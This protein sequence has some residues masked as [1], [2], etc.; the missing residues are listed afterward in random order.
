MISTW[1]PEGPVSS[2]F[3][4]A[5]ANLLKTMIGSGIL[6]LPYA[7]A[8][9][10]LLLSL[11]GLAVLAYLTQLAIRLVVRCTTHER[12]YGRHGP[13]AILEDGSP[14]DGHGGGSW[15]LISTAA[16]GKVGWSITSA[17]LLTAQL[18]VASSYLDFISQ[19]LVENS[20]LSMA[21]A[22]IILWAV[23]TSMSLLRHLRSVAF[24]SMGALGVYAAIGVLLCY[25][26][27]EA[28]A[29]QEPLLWFDPAG[30][31][32]WF[33]PSLFAF[34]GMGTALSI[35][36]SM[37]LADP[38]PYFAV[39]SS[40]YAIAFLLYGTVATVGYAAWGDD[41]AQVVLDSLPVSTLGTSAKLFLS[42]VLLL[43]YPLQMTAPYHMLEAWLPAGGAWWAVGRAGLVAVTAVA[44]YLIPNMEQMVALTGALAFSAIGF[45]LPGA[46]FLKLRPPELDGSAART[47]DVL[48]SVGMIMLGIIGGSW[49]VYTIVIP[50][51]L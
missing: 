41:V 36:E 46:I 22:R 25:Y 39:V 11:A 10:G 23:L 35:Y 29:R 9:V 51:G 44:S 27:L 31:G 33:G 4:H 47:A 43:T 7:T 16:F 30:L 8:R 18:G 32:A 2:G 21:S 38:R 50:Q 5:F 13:Y 15:Q 24:L 19:I 28:P 37:H 12:G 1:K 20:L 6:T 34:E 26:G 17:S 14:T 48:G 40:S 42:G 3:L 45:V 49:G